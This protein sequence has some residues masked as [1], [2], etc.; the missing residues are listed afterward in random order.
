MPKSLS[1][2]VWYQ[3]WMPVTAFFT[4]CFNTWINTLE[5]SPT[6]EVVN[7]SFKRERLIEGLV[8]EEGRWKRDG[9]GILYLGGQGIHLTRY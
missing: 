4:V 6:S 2:A 5:L 1:K 9:E 3:R 7:T 8:R